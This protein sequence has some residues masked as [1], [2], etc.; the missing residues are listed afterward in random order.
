MTT[1][2]DAIDANRFDGWTR[3]MLITEAQRTLFS[4]HLP[5]G[6][7][8]LG[9]G[10]VDLGFE[11]LEL[12]SAEL[13][14]VGLAFVGVGVR[15]SGTGYRLRHVR[16]G[17]SVVERVLGTKRLHWHT[18]GV[19]QFRS[20]LRPKSALIHKAVPVLQFTTSS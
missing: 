9:G 17:R 5:A 3:T 7:E 18:T 16:P 14:A 10:F 12:S 6:F 11:N 15:V 4:G 8:F 19:G 1:W 2:L 13:D 20:C